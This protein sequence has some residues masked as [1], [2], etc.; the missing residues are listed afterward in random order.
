MKPELV[1]KSSG[2]GRPASDGPRYPGGKLRPQIHDAAIKRRALLQDVTWGSNPLEAAFIAGWLTHAEFGAAKT[3]LRLRRRSYDHTLGPR[4]AQGCLPEVE[5]KELEVTGDKITNW[6]RRQIAAVWD[7]V[8]G[9]DAPDPEARSEANAK[10]AEQL[11]AIHAAMTEAE[12]LELIMVCVHES[13]PQWFVQRKAGEAIREKAAAEHRGLTDD[14]MARIR[15]RF[16]TSFEAKRDLLIK[17]LRVI[18]RTTQPE[19]VLAPMVAYDEPITEPVPHIPSNDP[20]GFERTEYIDRDGMLL[21]V[22]EWK[23]QRRA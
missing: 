3:Y 5:L 6:G 18:I 4:L 14:E 22:A 8:F 13:W 7:A 1:V 9:D 12:R 2:P 15:K 16:R 11:K 23:R 10:A 19:A 20:R 17:A 21:Y